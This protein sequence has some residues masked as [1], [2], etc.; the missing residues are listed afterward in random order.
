MSISYSH[1]WLYCATVSTTS[2]HLSDE[3][4]RNSFYSL[5]KDRKSEFTLSPF[6][7]LQPFKMQ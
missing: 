6:L 7:I 2:E 3:I 5:K 1:L 4:N